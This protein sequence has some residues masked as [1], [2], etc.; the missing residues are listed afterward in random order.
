[1]SHKLLI[2]DNPDILNRQNVFAPR[3]IISRADIGKV[4]PTQY[5]D[6]VLDGTDKELLHAFIKADKYYLPDGLVFSEDVVIL[7]ESFNKKQLYKPTIDDYNMGAQHT[8][9]ISAPANYDE[10]FDDITIS[11]QIKILEPLLEDNKIGAGTIAQLTEQLVE[12]CK[13]HKLFERDVI[14]GLW[15][16]KFSKKTLVSEQHALVL[17]IMHFCDKLAIKTTTYKINKQTDEPERTYKFT[18]IKE[19]ELKNIWRSISLF[20]TFN[21]RKE[22]YDSIPEW[23][24][25]ERIRT[26]MKDYFECDTNPNF[27]LL[28]ITSII[29]KFSPKNDYVPYFFDI[30]SPSKGI[31]KT[32]L[33]HRLLGGKY[34]SF[35]TFAVGRRDDFFVNAYDSNAVLELDDE[36]TWVTVKGGAGHISTDE[37]KTLVTTSIDKFSRKFG[38]PEEHDRSFI[39]VR[40]SNYVNTVFSTNERRQ[41]IFECALPEQECR[42]KD[43]PDS[44]FQQ[45]LAEAKKYYE[46]HHGIYQ[47]TDS[48]KIEVNA[49]NL[50]NFNWESEDLYTILD[51]INAVRQDPLK[52]KECL[53][54]QK[55][56]DKLYGSYK[57]YTDWCR[58]NKRTAIKSRAFWRLI[59][60]MT[61]QKNYCITTE[62][63]KIHL[64]DGG[65]SRIIKILPLPLAE[66]LVNSL[67]DL[68]Y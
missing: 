50:E 17:F 18:R 39:I 24:G 25:T 30:V 16:T 13:T 54:Y 1:M 35:G 42:I 14:T 56:N 52:W 49:A 20:S 51:Y 44:F 11:G 22:F 37:F 33:C 7:N 21:S 63:K 4:D 45:L 62:Q 15:R 28:F 6:V 32:Y 31:G 23:D 27:F 38:Q 43:L 64:L 29:A 26:F 8:S 12:L 10:S 58:E 60:A 19:P 40:T 55:H 9:F 48:D 57:K 68:P 2:T 66:E 61:S 59:D 46:E 5:S 36:C 47:L 34:L 65:K 67:P 53:K 3:K 41:I